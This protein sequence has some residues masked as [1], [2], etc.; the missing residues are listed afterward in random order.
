M[1]RNPPKTKV[2]QAIQA[3]AITGPSTTIMLHP[4]LIV[5]SPTNPRKTFPEESLIELGATMVADGQI[6]P[7]TVRTLP[8]SRLE[9]TYATAAAEGKPRPTHELVVGERRW[10]AARLAGIDLRCEV[11]ELTDLQVV[12]IQILENLHREE[13]HPLEEAEGYEYLLH[14]SSEDI[15]IEQ[16]AEEV[17]KSTSYVYQRMKLCE[18]CK[19]ARER[20]YAGDFDA[21]TALL[22]ARLDGEVLQM[23]AIQEIKGMGED[24][25][26]PS[27]R[28]IRAMLRQRFHLNLGAAPFETTD[29]TLVPAA[30]SCAACPKRTGNQPMLFQDVS[31]VDTCTDPDCFDSKRKASVARTIEQA[32]KEGLQVIEG[33]DAH[34][35][36][37]Y[38]GANWL[39]GFTKLDDEA[40][41]T[42]DGDTVTYADLLEMA[43]KK[44]PKL[45][46][47]VDDRLPDSQ[48]DR[49]LSDEAA[50]ALLDKF[51][52][53]AKAAQRTPEEIE[54]ERDREARQRRA[55]IQSSYNSRLRAALMDTLDQ[56]RTTA[57]ML[58]AVFAIIGGDID[59]E[60]LMAAGVPDDAVQAADYE[61]GINLLLEQLLRLDGQ[62]LARFLMRMALERD[63]NTPVAALE[64]AAQSHDVD[65]AA[66]LQD[67]EH[68]V[69]GSNDE[70]DDE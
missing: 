55:R 14:H 1:T 23:R 44:A 39:S 7:A 59:D 16:V 68:A 48:P 41:E 36:R 35:V 65:V 38:A 4:D 17:G 62:Q 53:K 8:A 33:E 18:L 13:V 25:E 11:R 50:Q 29:A 45:T 60:V 9:D 61:E 32:R 2:A 58:P 26:A 15:T 54:E 70:D 56:P 63:W 51:K 21:S 34:K 19:P 3:P 6:Q 46:L 49:L 10:R 30:G 5:A 31:S 66:L 20:F 57:D 43:G 27:Y 64:R 40:F 52:P 47:L 67:A 28:Q 37:P 22:I 42:E 24:D 69:D 12:R